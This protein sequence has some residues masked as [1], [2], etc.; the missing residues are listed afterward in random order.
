MYTILGSFSGVATE[1]SLG[2]SSSGG[3]IG[4]FLSIIDTSRTSGAGVASGG[5]VRRVSRVEGLVNFFSEN[6]CVESEAEEG[7]EILCQMR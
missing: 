4:G 6:P 3:E 5:E 7:T 2:S 1:S